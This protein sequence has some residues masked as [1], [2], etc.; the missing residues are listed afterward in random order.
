MLLGFDIVKG[1]E[2]LLL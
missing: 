2:V 1:E